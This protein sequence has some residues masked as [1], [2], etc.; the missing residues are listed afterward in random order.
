MQ[1]FVSAVAVLLSA[2][3]GLVRADAADT[4]EGF[5][6]PPRGSAE[7]AELRARLANVSSPVPIILTFVFLAFAGFAYLVW[8]VNAEGAKLPPKP[9]KKIGAKK[10]AKLNAKESDM[11]Q[12]SD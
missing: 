1:R 3:F 12:E 6:L 4:D 5:P 8:K 10:R 7:E 11:Y 2:A 9:K